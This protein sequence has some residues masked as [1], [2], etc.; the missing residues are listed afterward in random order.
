[1]QA[2]RRLRPWSEDAPACHR[3]RRRRHLRTHHVMTAAVSAQDDEI[4]ERGM[5]FGILGSLLSRDNGV[6]LSVGSAQLRIL[7][8][9]LL[10]RA[11]EPV[12]SAGLAATIW[13]ERAPDR[14]EETIR[15]YVMRLRRALGP[16]AGSRIVTR[17][18]GY[19]IQIAA[20]EFDVTRF[21]GLCDQGSA[22]L[23]AGDCRM[24]MVT[25]AKA[26]AL[27][28][29]SP[30]ADVPSKRLRDAEVPQLEQFRLQAQ[31][32]R[33][34]AA[35]RL[36]RGAQF[37][38]ELKTLTADHPL[39]E[40]LHAQ[41]MVALA[42][43][44]CQAEALAA[45]QR[46]RGS[47]VAELGIEPNPGLQRLQRRILAHDRD[48]FQ[49]RPDDDHELLTLT[50]PRP[51]IAP[52][53]R[54][55]PAAVPH[56][57]GRM[58]ELAALTRQ[59]DEAAGSGAAPVISVICGMPGVGKTALAVHW[60]HQVAARFPDGQLYI[61]LRGSGSSSNP[62]AAEE[63]LEDFLISLG[64]AA[65]AVPAT[66]SARAGLYRSLLADR[67]MLVV[68]DNA[69]DSQQVR[70]LLP[71]GASCFVLVTSR[72]ELAGLAA[73]EGAAQFALGV[74]TDGE[75]QRFLGKRL[76]AGVAAREPAAV[77]EISRLCSSL[78]LALSMA[79]AR[80]A[81]RP[82]FPLNALVAELH[83]ASGRPGPLDTGNGQ[84]RTGA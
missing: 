54:Q 45:Y 52:A 67:R 83:D 80:A 78:P 39:H 57:T 82:A 26:L 61:S 1:V 72:E 17:E 44:G 24:A 31:Q 63:A 9:A 21:T 36:G 48:L 77:E 35:L 4:M 50:G 10:V 58:A 84:D 20:D 19:C 27:W 13:G 69:R 68:L 16:I 70:P 60:A 49:V 15:T 22:A 71:G 38:P 55:L 59:L 41:L 33:I 66:L 75:A 56:F 29:G 18:R 65:Q 5:F 28:R 11:N 43:S 81:T 6:E 64:V 40:T 62:V 46:V 73:V 37:V 51:A 76:K 7:L 23:R 2:G 3:E 25:L 47:L 8:A 32:S 74:F 42:Q 53:P 14:A 34:E 12:F 79:A 30:L